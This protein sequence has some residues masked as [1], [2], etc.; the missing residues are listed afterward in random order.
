MQKNIFSYIL[1]I[2]LLLFSC[3]SVKNTSSL[4]AISKSL[5]KT[6]T[7]HY[8]T[9]AWG[10]TYKEDTFLWTWVSHFSKAG[11]IM[12]HE[13]A[14]KHLTIFEYDKNDSLVYFLK[15]NQHEVDENKT[16]SSPPLAPDSVLVEIDRTENGLRKTFQKKDINHSP[17][18]RKVKTEWVKYE[19]DSK[20]RKSK[21][22]HI[23]SDG[24]EEEKTYE[25]QDQMVI[26]RIRYKG[27]DKKLLCSN[28]DTSYFDEQG[29]MIKTGQASNCN[30]IRSRSFYSC[31]NCWIYRDYDA[32]KNLEKLVRVSFEGD[33][34][35]GFQRKYDDR[36][37]VIWSESFNAKGEKVRKD[38]VVEKI[39]N[40]QGDC[41][42]FKVIENGEVLRAEKF[43]Y[44]YW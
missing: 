36:N 20:N 6:K 38:F 11:N 2:F 19:H 43:A 8:W 28:V 24:S 23:K 44:E 13:E 9:S 34:I 40:E 17:N 41:T 4:P 29:M 3:K 18:H 31:N 1:W 15:I 5:V 42:F 26:T 25:Y 39:F 32:N 16:S 22:S 7:A 27:K 37:E 33:T 21:S 14:E 35:S 10:D 30:P 12:L